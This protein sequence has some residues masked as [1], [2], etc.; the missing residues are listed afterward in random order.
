M[1]GFFD[2]ERVRGVRYEK[3]FFLRFSSSL[4]ATMFAVYWELNHQGAF[5]ERVRSADMYCKLNRPQVSTSTTAEAKRAKPGRKCMQKDTVASVTTAIQ[6]T[7]P[8]Q[9][10][11]ACGSSTNSRKSRDNDSYCGVSL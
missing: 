9:D 10:E 6:T 2:M 7:G 11:S 8:F 5:L 1:T 3:F 4:Y